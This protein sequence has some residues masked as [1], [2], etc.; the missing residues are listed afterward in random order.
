MEVITKINQ[1][2]IY[3]A[4]VQCCFTSGF[5]PYLLYV[6]N[7]QD[8]FGELVGK[9]T[10]CFFKYLSKLALMSENQKRP[11]R[12]KIALQYLQVDTDGVDYSVNRQTVQW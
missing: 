12:F 2:N 1:S 11:V 7:I 8:F 10:V 6:L 4:S 9:K 5:T 3:I